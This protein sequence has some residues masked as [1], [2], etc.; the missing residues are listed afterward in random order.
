[1]ELRSMAHVE[2]LMQNTA[3]CGPLERL[4]QLEKYSCCCWFITP[5]LASGDMQ[6]ATIYAILNRAYDVMK[7]L[8]INM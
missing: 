7:E 4:S 5:T 2:M 8:H 3:F 6:D 1:M